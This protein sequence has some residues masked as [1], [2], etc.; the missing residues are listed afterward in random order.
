[1]MRKARLLQSLKHWDSL[2]T[3]IWTKV[4]SLKLGDTVQMILDHYADGTNDVI[5]AQALL[6]A[7]DL[8]VLQH[9]F[10]QAAQFYKR[11]MDM[12]DKLGASDLIQR[13]RVQR[14]MYF[15]SSKGTIQP[16]VLFT[17]S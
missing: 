8:A 15:C 14:L 13:R 10:D 12:A 1:M 11:S 9:Q 2:L 6:R 4:N 16:L 7:G 5:E 3:V 17:R